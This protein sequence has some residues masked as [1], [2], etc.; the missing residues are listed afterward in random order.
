MRNLLI[1]LL[2]LLC[3]PCIAGTIN[4]SESAS[5][6]FGYERYNRYLNMITI[7]MELDGGASLRSLGNFVGTG[8]LRYSTASADSKYF[9]KFGL[10][11]AENLSHQCMLFYT[12]V[13]SYIRS[14]TFTVGWWMRV[15]EIASVSSTLNDG[16]NVYLRSSGGL[17]YIRIG[18]VY[19]PNASDT[20]KL[21]AKMGVRYRYGAVNNGFDTTATA[22]LNV[23][24]WNHF[25]VQ[26]YFWAGNYYIVFIVNGTTLGYA[27]NIQA[28]SGSMAFAQYIWLGW[29]G[30]GTPLT[31]YTKVS[32]SVDDFF[33][34]PTIFNEQ[35]PPSMTLT[36][37]GSLIQK[38]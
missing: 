28:A 37:F 13:D 22:T 26:R 8:I 23:G 36:N 24:D 17:D 7:P 32:V 1:L 21:D 3:L 12:G 10:K 34:T 11:M 30:F 2:V 27:V 31:D 33:Y 35:T 20:T 9:N 14:S 6:Q 19:Y 25:M 29:F 4:F 5:L 38:K 18:L 16:F 15:D